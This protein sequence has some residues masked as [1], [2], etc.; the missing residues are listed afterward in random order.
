MSIDIE[1]LERINALLAKLPP[2]ALQSQSLRPVHSLVITPSKSQ[3]DI[4]L[5][6]LKQMPRAVRTLFRVLGVSSK[7]GPDTGGA[8][9]SYLLFEAQYTQ[10]LIRLGRADSFNRIDD[11]RAF[12]KETSG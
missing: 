7:S 9:L 4:A 2:D 12:F 10:E 6:H 1:R 11:I 5:V 3:D 8:L